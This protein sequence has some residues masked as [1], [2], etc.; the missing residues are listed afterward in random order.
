VF[1]SLRNGSIE[2]TKDVRPPVQQMTSR[3]KARAETGSR[4]MAVM[5]EI[6]S[7]TPT[8]Y[9]FPLHV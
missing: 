5:E 8:F 7:S 3:L 4:N 6:K 1:K 2:C 9:L